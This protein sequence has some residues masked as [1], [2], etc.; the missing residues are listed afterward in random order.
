MGMLHKGSLWLP[1]GK[2]IQTLLLLFFNFE[3]LKQLLGSFSWERIFEK[4]I[5]HYKTKRQNS[6]LEVIIIKLRWVQISIHKLSLK[7]TC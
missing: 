1:P 5:H 4:Y 7:S 3:A 2:F 6:Y